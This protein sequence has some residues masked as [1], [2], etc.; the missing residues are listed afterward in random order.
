MYFF[1]IFPPKP[2]MTSIKLLW[3]PVNCNRRI[4]WTAQVGVRLER[5]L[6][7]AFRDTY[8]YLWIPTF[9]L[10][11]GT[12]RNG[13]RGK[14]LRGFLACCN[15]GSNKASA[16]FSSPVLSVFV[17]GGIYKWKTL[18]NSVWA[19]SISAKKKKKHQQKSLGW[20]GSLKTWL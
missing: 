3:I 18:C 20:F 9:S 6:P 4:D 2:W 17:W 1:A 11:S 8:G 5:D 14:Q 19:P 15:R 10:A 7:H 16:V 12:D 13:I